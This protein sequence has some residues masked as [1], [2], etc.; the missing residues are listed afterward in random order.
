[1]TS[2]AFLLSSAAAYPVLFV[3]CSA[4]PSLGLIAGGSAEAIDHG[5]NDPAV[6]PDTM[7]VGQ[8]FA[9]ISVRS[10]V[11]QKKGIAQI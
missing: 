10:K 9:E 7:R 11:H 8:S 1:M 3:A 5:E 2:Q 4:I 6:V